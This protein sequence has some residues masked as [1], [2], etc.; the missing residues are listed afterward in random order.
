MGRT[1]QMTDK[2]FHFVRHHEVA[3]YER[4][5]WRRHGSLDGTHHGY[6]SSLMEWKGEGEPVKPAQVAASPKELG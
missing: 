3:D 5:G 6:W 4:V 2:I 1:C